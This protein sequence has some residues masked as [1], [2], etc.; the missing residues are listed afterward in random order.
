MAINKP[1]TEYY[2]NCYY[3]SSKLSQIKEAAANGDISENDLKDIMKSYDEL[4]TTQ[5]MALMFDGE[6]SV[7]ER[8]AIKAAKIRLNDVINNNIKDKDYAETEG[9][10][11]CVLVGIDDEIQE[12]QALMNIEGFIDWTHA[13]HDN[14][15]GNFLNMD[16]NGPERID[17]NAFKYALD[18]RVLIPKLN[19]WAAM[20]E[21]PNFDV[22]NLP[23]E[24]KEFFPP[25]LPMSPQKAANFFKN[26][27]DAFE[28]EAM[29][30][31][32]QAPKK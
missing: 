28:K 17:A 6:V 13:T 26:L 5:T 24:A 1:R 9:E 22:N 29:H 27:A 23:E 31:F 11:R 18:L 2:N 15:T 12:I 32:D 19:N 14:F 3:N 21:R 16:L 25:D 20:C 8:K 10:K 7:G 4:K 30:I